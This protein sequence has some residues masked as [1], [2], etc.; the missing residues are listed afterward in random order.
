MASALLINDTDLPVTYVQQGLPAS[1]GF[2]LQPKQQRIFTYTNL[3][4][5]GIYFHKINE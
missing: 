2:E 4:M 3:S 5:K 1:A